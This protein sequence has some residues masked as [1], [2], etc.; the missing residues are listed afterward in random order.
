MDKRLTRGAICLLIGGGAVYFGYGITSITS[1][2]KLMGNAM[3]VS[4]VFGLYVLVLGLSSLYDLVLRSEHD[5]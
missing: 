5:E 4:L 1:D 3:I 2:D